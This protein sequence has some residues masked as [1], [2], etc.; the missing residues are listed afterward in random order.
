[1]ETDA[2]RKKRF[3]SMS[4]AERR[5]LIREK[6]KA[7]GLEEGSGVPGKDL[8]SYDEDEIWDLIQILSSFK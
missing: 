4:S 8:S 1:M 5:I 7:Q 2:E 6:M 3:Q